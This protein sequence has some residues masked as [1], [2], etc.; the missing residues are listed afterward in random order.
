MGKKRYTQQIARKSTST[1][2]PPPE[3]EEILDMRHG[4]KIGSVEYLV[5][6][7]N[8]TNEEATWEPKI[9]GPQSYHVMKKYHARKEFEKLEEPCGTF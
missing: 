5:R 2:P 1:T 9:K 3:P 4:E 7:K 6:W 8:S